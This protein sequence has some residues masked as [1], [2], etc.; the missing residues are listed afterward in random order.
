MGAFGPSVSANSLAT[1]DLPDGFITPLTQ[2]SENI[3]EERHGHTNIEAN[4]NPSD[5]RRHPANQDPHPVS[6]SL[7]PESLQLY[8]NTQNDTVRN[9][10]R[11]SRL[12]DVRRSMIE[13]LPGR[14]DHR[15][16]SKASATLFNNA[17]QTASSS[18]LNDVTQD[19][20]SCGNSIEERLKACVVESEGNYRTYVPLNDIDGIVTKE[21]VDADLSR[22]R[23]SKDRYIRMVRKLGPVPHVPIESPKTHKR[24][25]SDPFLMPA[26]RNVKTYRLI[27]AILSFIGRPSHIWNFVEEEVCDADLPLR[28]V[29]EKDRFYLRR[30]A[31]HDSPLRCLRNRSLTV[32]FEETQW[33]M[34]APHF[35]RSQITDISRLSGKTNV[36]QLAL[37]PKQ[38][39][40]FMKWKRICIGGF[41]RVYK[42]KIHPKH[43]DFDVREV[44]SDRI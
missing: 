29:E 8:V 3:L 24:I 21:T 37:R 5:Q 33:I 1:S 36:P 38:P 23:N 12:Q 14:S 11:N 44:S 9:A 18:Q 32:E 10:K 4:V 35:C 26:K 13:R 42:A 27:F 39:L 2:Y 34:L 7:Q 22:W 43:H 15:R 41:S 40:P 16:L 30:Q 6:P 25:R 19:Y 17:D 31:R 20:F 28:K